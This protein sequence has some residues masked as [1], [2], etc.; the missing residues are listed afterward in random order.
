MDRAKVT[1]LTGATGFIGRHVLRAVL[2][3]GWRVR[4]LVRDAA[5]LE[6][7]PDAKAQVEVVT[8]ALEDEAALKAL[9]RGADAVV[10]LAGLVKAARPE[11]FEA[12]NVRA[13][14]DVARIAREAGVR[15]FVHVSSLAAREPRL[16]PYARSKHLSEEAVLEASR[17]MN[18]VIVRPPAVYGPGDRATL[19]LVDQLSRRHAFLPGSAQGRISLIH[20]ADLAAAIAAL[21]GSDG[22]AGERLEIDDGKAGGYGLRELGALAGRAL[23]RP[24][25]V[26]LLPRALVQLAGH[27]ADMAARLTGRGFMLSRAKA[28]ELYHE[29]WVARGPKVEDK[30]DWTARLGFAQGFLDALRW[31][32]RAGWL[33][34]SRLPENEET[35]G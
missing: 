3:D 21:A 19:G 23:G 5:R 14:A 28:N 13:A 18:C 33:P 32:C 22:G 24:V 30:A 34:K 4:A 17:E 10:H 15:R 9:S 7:P 1:A 25:S 35:D 20:A 26:H 29:D 6:I 16:S 11:D 12:V 31:Y 2:D 8:G 27:G